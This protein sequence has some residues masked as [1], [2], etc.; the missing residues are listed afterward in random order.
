[1]AGPFRVID[2]R[3]PSERLTV[4]GTIVRGGAECP[5][6]RS[7]DGRRYSLTGDLGGFGPGDRVEVTGRLA[8]VSICMQ[9]PTLEVRRISEAE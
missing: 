1:V 7:D 3:P 5:L 4:T 6:F 2:R 9:G 8:E